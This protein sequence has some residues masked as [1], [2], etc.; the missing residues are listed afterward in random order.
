MTSGSESLDTLLV[1]Q[2]YD[3]AEH[4][5]AAKA[6][7]GFADRVHTTRRVADIA[8]AGVSVPASRLDLVNHRV[9][10][11]DIH[12]D[13]R[14]VP[15]PAARPPLRQY[16]RPCGWE[17]GE[18]AGGCGAERRHSALDE[19]THPDHALGAR[20]IGAG[21]HRREMRHCEGRSG[22]PVD[23]AESERLLDPVRSG[24]LDRDCGPPDSVEI[25][26]PIAALMIYLI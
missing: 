9:R 15:L 25:F 4:V 1:E 6:A 23:V 3:I 26:D 13:Q 10:V 17:E 19:Q 7:D 12:V 20:A 5:E 16:P 22:D 18:E 8:V 24:D 11:L 21:Q 14:A 2:A